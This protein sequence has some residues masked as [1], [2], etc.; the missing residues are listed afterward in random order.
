MSSQKLNVI[1]SFFVTLVIIV[2]KPGKL[3][4]QF[5]EKRAKC[6]LV[7]ILSLLMIKKIDSPTDICNAFNSILA[8]IGKKSTAKI[9]L[10]GKIK[11]RKHYLGPRQQSLIFLNPTDEFKVLEEIQNL[12][13]RKP[14]GNIDTPSSFI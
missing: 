5:C 10:T 8:N 14:P 4:K 1:K 2:L 3:S 13:S 7:P 6:F 11:S 12:S 9:K